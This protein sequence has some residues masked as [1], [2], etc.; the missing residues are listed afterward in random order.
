MNAAASTVLPAAGTRSVRALIGGE[1]GSGRLLGLFRTAAYLQIR[2]DEVVAVLTRDAVRLP[3][4]LVLAQNS[5]DGPLDQLVG[6]ILV[7]DG[8]VSIGSL[9]VRLVRTREAMVATGLSPRR[10]SVAALWARLETYSFSEHDP[11][12]VHALGDY[13]DSAAVAQPIVDALVGAG[14]GLTPSGDDILAGFLVAARAVGLPCPALADTALLRATRNTTTLSAALLRYAGRGETIPQIARLLHS[15]SSASEPSEAALE[16]LTR[17]LAIGHTS[18]TAMATGV[19]AA[20][21]SRLSRDPSV[22]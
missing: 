20:C 19:L 10:E 15:L 12:I 7:G 5:R 9:T 6:P 3:C 13:E 14:S 16:A 4:G 8:Q 18:G 21:R 22:P 11:Q 2:G 1:P 17:V